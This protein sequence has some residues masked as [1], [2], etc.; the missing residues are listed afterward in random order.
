MALELPA[1]KTVKVKGMVV[2]ALRIWID[3]TDKIWYRR[4]ARQAVAG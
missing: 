3:W 2:G 4:K 1:I